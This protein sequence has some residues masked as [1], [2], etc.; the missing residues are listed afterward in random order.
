M[1][2]ERRRVTEPEAPQPEAGYRWLRAQLVLALLL[3][4]FWLLWSGI[5]TPLLLFLGAL[6]SLL[7][8]YIV[9]RMGYFDTQV[10]AFR[11]N[12]RLIGFWLWLLREIVRSSIEV[13]RV[14]LSMPMRLSTEVVEV[15]IGDLEPVDQALLGNSITLTPGTLTLD[16]RQ[17]RLVVHALTPAGAQSLRDGDMKRRVIA[18]RRA[19]AA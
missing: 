11:Y 1:R 4:A 18:L 19:K 8:V 9:K 6:S 15:P 7:S 2:S 17:D 10:Y 12:F 14:V 5:F 3:V 13:A 16:T